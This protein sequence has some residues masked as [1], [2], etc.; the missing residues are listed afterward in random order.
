MGRK[1]I[2]FQNVTFIY[3]SASEPLFQ[4][5]SLHFASGWSGIVGSNG[6]GKTTLLK[7]ATGLVEAN[8]GS[9]TACQNSV[10]CPQ[11][12]DDIPEKLS[13]LISG[14]TKSAYIIKSR[15]GVCDDWAE[16]WTTLSH[17][18]RKRA[19][20][21]VALWLRPD[22]LAIDEPTNHIDSQACEIITQALR[23]FKGVGLIV[24]H[25]RE[26]LDLLCQQCFFIEPPD[27]ITCPGGVTKG[28]EIAKTE[29]RSLEKQRIQRKHVYKTLQRETVRRRELAIKSHKMRSKRGLAKKDHDA[30]EKKDRARV[31]GKDGVGGRLH[32]QLKGRL[33]QTR[34]NLENI[35]VKKQHTLG[36]WLPG[37]VSKRNFLLELPAGSLSLGGQKQLH[38][39]ELHINP[40]DR[41]AVTGPNGSGKSTLIQRI[42]NS[43]NVSKKHITYVPQEIDLSCSQGI[44]A[45]ALA[46]SKDKLGHLMTIVS[47]LGS[48]PDKLLNSD[49]PS[50]GE[51]RKLLL[52]I[53]MTF[54]PHIVVMDEPTN[55]MDLPSIEC[56]EQALKDCP[57]G[58]LLVSHDKYFLNKLTSKKWNIMPDTSSRGRYVLSTVV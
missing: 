32:R 39:P 48:R 28:M 58:L 18:E 46:L 53:G 41:I 50:P 22:V 49:E 40:I 21:A 52:A 25:N 35:S 14:N 54:T 20:I 4:N 17:G 15:L 37:S 23:S 56:L 30:R 7:L 10:Y 34:K 44:L 2:K 9:I 45:Q 12:T 5:I 36:I 42:V 11:R 43:L 38:Y 16:R 27:I 26:L 57:C 19:Q 13:E 6:A 29:Q 8:T 24:S 1:N 31:S 51:T 3:D 47:R 55:H 33:D